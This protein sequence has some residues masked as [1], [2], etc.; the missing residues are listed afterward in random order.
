MIPLIPC[1][2]IH[3]GEYKNKNSLLNHGFN[4]I[5]FRGVNAKNDEHLIHQDRINCKHTCPKS[6]IGCALSHILLAQKLYDENVSLAL[7]LEDDAYPKTSFIDFEQIIEDVPEDWDIIRLHC[8][9]HCKDG[10][11]SI[12]FVNGSSASYIINQSGINKLKDMKV[13]THVDVQMSHFSPL[14]VYKSRTNLFR[15]DESSSNIRSSGI[16]KHWASTFMMDPTSGEKT[17][18][19]I[20]MY[21][22]FRV[23]GTNIEVTFG[24]LI[25]GTVILLVLW[26]LK[27]RLSH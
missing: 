17:K 23:P 18:D 22:L 14:N 3:L 8:D 19:M 20:F 1:Y 7:V 25:N 27:N 4:P 24:Q 13:E 11:T 6:T 5:G 26:Y 15:T 16:S 2:V 21:K 10:S 9:M 12:G